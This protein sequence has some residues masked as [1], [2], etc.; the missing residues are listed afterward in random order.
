[1]DNLARVQRRFIVAVT[2]LGVINLAL[3]IY[4]LWGG[5]SGPSLESLQQQYNALEREV[6][7]RQKGNPD[8][9]RTDLKQFYSDNLPS[10][11]SQISE[12]VEK[13]TRN[14]GV[15]AQSIH[16][17]T[18]SAEKAEKNLPAGVQQVKIETNVTGDYAKVARFINELEQDRML[19]II[20]KISLSGQQG[21]L[22]SLQITFST[23]VQTA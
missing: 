18:E 15:T 17:P 2:V 13:L 16:Y 3:V 1:M 23:F 9:T 14:A 6:E 20:E 11:G 8:Q 22:V 5:P 10:R 7:S 4:L 21:G 12:Q 19:F